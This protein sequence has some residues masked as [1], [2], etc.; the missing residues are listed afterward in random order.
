[1]VP[2]PVGGFE[3]RGSYHIELKYNIT[4]A[5]IQAL[6][7]ESNTCRQWLRWQCK[8]AGIKV[9]TSGS[10]T[11]VGRGVVR[12]HIASELGGS[13]VELQTID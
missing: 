8:S 6:I 12:N 7:V 10:R 4:D 1:M 3:E 2:T 11:S 9:G 5:Q 13:G